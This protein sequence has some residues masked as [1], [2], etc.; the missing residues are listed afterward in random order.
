M[1]L[2]LPDD[3]D[4]SRLALVLKVNLLLLALFFGYSNETIL[5]QRT[6]WIM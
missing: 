5:A 1:Q 2:L 4:D 6:A 3:D